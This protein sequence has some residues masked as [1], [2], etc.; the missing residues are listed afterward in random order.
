MGAGGAG[1][2][3]SSITSAQASGRR[4]GGRRHGVQVVTPNR[5]GCFAHC[6]GATSAGLRLMPAP[7]CNRHRPGV[8]Y[9]AIVVSG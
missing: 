4:G 2:A 8:W 7:A 5:Y 3:G 9:L 1:G 6:G